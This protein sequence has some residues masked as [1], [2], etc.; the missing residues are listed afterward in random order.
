MH[1]FLRAAGFS[2]YQKKKDIRALLRCLAREAGTS[3]CLQLDRETE[4]YEI[5]TEVAPGIGV[6]MYG[7]L[8]E[9]DEMEIEYYYPYILN[10]EVTSRAECSIQRHTE[11]ETYAGLLDEYKVGLSLIFYLLNPIEYRECYRK[12]RERLQVTSVS[13]AGFANRGKV[14]LPIKKT[15]KVLEVG[16]GCGAITGALSRK[17]GSVT[18]VDLSKKRSMINAYRHSE[19]ENV[20]IHIGNFTDV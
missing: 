11:K 13:L 12:E 15:D 19:S 3:S 4:L 6:A 2:M 10:E 16:S 7:E 17:A 14:L 18:C 1:R 8:N 20:T 5:K 9:Q